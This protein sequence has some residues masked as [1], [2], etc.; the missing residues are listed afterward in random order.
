M[1]RA[2]RRDRREPRLGLRHRR[3]GAP[4]D[5]FT[6]RAIHAGEPITATLDWFVDRSLDLTTGVAS[7][8]SFDQLT[9]QVWSVNGGQLSTLIAQSCDPYDTVQHL[10]FSAPSDG[11]YAIQVLWAG[12]VY[13][14]SDTPSTSDDYGLAWSVGVPEPATMSLLIFGAFAIIRRRRSDH[15]SQA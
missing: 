12:N 5:Y 11:M 1:S 10:Y 13:D 15:K 4:N 9:L 14:L 3:T 6:T 7:D 8:V 2:A